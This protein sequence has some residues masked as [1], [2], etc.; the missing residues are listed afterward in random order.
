MDEL[1]GKL[2]GLPVLGAF[3]KGAEG[4]STSSEFGLL[5]ALVAIATANAS[6]MTLAL[7]LC[8]GLLGVGVGLFAIARGRVKVEAAVTAT[9]A[10]APAAAALLLLLLPSVLLAGCSCTLE[11][12]ALA[13]VGDVIP[14]VAD[15]IHPTNA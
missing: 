2:K 13:R 15:D 5:A 11:R 8:L 14:R 1:L 6:S 10:K 4:G 12:D 3:F 7:G 9:P